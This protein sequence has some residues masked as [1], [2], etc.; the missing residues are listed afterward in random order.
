MK[1][2][3]SKAAEKWNWFRGKALPISVGAVM[4]VIA[5]IAIGCGGS[6]ST[7]VPFAGV[8][9]A[10]GGGA[11]ALH[12]TGAELNLTGNVNINPKTKT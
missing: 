7:I 9:V 12:F 8:W 4:A 11:D 3:E 5:A 1:V 2:K 6:S 10:N